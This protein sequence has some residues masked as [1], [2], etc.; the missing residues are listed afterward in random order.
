MVRDG[1]FNEDYVAK[2]EN[3][4]GVR[5]NTFVYTLSVQFIFR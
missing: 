1:I 4:K 3:E 2:T 5:A